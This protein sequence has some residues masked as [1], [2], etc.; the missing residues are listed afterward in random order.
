MRYYVLSDIHGFFSLA[1]KA[2][3]RAGYFSDISP[4][5]LI[6]CG[7]LFDRGKEA[8]ELQDFIVDLIQ[9]DEVILIKGN[10]EDLA[11]E[12]IDNIHDYMDGS[13]K[14]THH[15][16][17]GTV[18]TI[19]DLVGMDFGQIRRSQ[20]LFADSIAEKFKQTPFYKIIIPAMRNYFETERYIFVHGWIPCATGV[21]KHW[22]TAYVGFNED[23]RSASEEKWEKARW[24]N[25]MK[26]AH[27][28]V[29][30]P[31]KVIVCGH[32]HCSYGWAKIRHEREE[33]PDEHTE[34]WQKS[35]EPYKEP[36]I[37]AIDGCTAYSG[38][39]NCIVLDD[40]ELKS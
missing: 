7:D 8:L 33:F 39:V 21:D 20:E 12:F 32:Y 25:G 40:E 36:G 38:I 2:L 29:F 6:V 1:K 10:H 24:Y 22:D 14:S 28:G 23:W 37:I 5:K 31:N 13:V 35:Y 9:K 16:E 19:L 27:S 30:V 15:W 26:A 34:G 17:N 18:Q 4:H 3:E 11:L